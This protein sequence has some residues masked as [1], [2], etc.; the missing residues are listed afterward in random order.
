MH[1]HPSLPT[2][3]KKLAELNFA[4]V[5]H[6]MFD[7]M[8]W[9]APPFSGP[10][11]IEHIHGPQCECNPENAVRV[12]FLRL[13]HNFYD[14]DFLGNCNK[15]HILSKSE[16]EQFIRAENGNGNGNKRSSGSGSG[17]ANGA[18]GASD[19]GDGE[20]GLIMSKNNDDHNNS[21]T[22]I[23]FTFSETDS[24]ILSKIMAALIKEPADSVY[25]FWLSACVENFLRGCGQL[26]QLFV[27]NSGVLVKTAK[28]IVQTQNS[29]TNSLQV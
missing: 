11:A 24:G 9:G 18:S 20:D 15:F 10:N 8:S 21:N 4:D 26:G 16:Q 25:R 6:N 19:N 12:Q 23:T 29:L 1:T 13:I 3:Q 14:R 27:A 28:H 2:L 7:R 22:P 17:G 5:L